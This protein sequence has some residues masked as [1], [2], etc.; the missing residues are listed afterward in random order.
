VIWSSLIGWAVFAVLVLLLT[1][2]ARNLREFVR[3]A[4]D[5]PRQLPPVSILFPRT[6]PAAAFRASV[7][8]LLAQEYPGDLQVMALEPEDER[9]HAALRRLSITSDRLLIISPDPSIGPHEQLAEAAT[10]EFLYTVIVPAIHEPRAVAAAVA[11]AL[12]NDLELL[13]IVPR[14][15]METFAHRMLLPLPFF[16]EATCSLWTATSTRVPPG[17]GELLLVRRYR[18]D[19]GSGQ[20]E[21]EGAPLAQ[22]GE[23]RVEVADGW[24][25]AESAGCTTGD[26]SECLRFRLAPAARQGWSMAVGASLLFLFTLPPIAAALTRDFPWIVA[27]VLGIWLRLRTTARTGEPFPFALLHPLSAA[28]TAGILWLRTADDNLHERRAS[29][30]VQRNDGH[31]R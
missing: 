4:E 15:R 28:V 29:A 21:A 9:D 12:E 10:G 14:Q 13:A 7:A 1:I 25:L 2:Q 16:I 24:T 5:V 3:P 6:E 18:G 27:T 26:V 8:S 31:T 23:R 19:A 30:P 17:Q 22:Q 11:H 20:S